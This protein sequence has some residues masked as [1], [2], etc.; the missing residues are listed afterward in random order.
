M[1]ADN[2]ELT[3]PGFQVLLALAAGEGHGYGVMKYV[4]ELSHGEVRLPPGTLYRT[5]ARL[6]ADG[7]A[8]EIG[9]EDPAASHDARRRYY[10][11]TETGREVAARHA[12]LLSRLVA[13]AQN[14]G[15][16]IDGTT[17]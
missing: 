5:I 4:Q 1:A 10:H 6:V 9:D 12:A 11:I 3:S 13:A 15:L 17:P 14:A 2:V 8:E 7:M 16:L